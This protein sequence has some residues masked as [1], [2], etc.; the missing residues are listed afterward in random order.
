MEIHYFTIG[1][2]FQLGMF[3]SQYKGEIYR[4]HVMSCHIIRQ[5]S[6]TN[7]GWFNPTTFRPSIQMHLNNG[8][9]MAKVLKSWGKPSKQ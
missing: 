6:I 2:G 7:N 5:S 9:A 1:H 4:G 3:H 8:I